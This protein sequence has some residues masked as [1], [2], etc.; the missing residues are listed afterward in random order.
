[1]SLTTGQMHILTLVFEDASVFFPNRVM[2]LR[3]VYGYIPGRL[4]SVLLPLSAGGGRHRVARV[5][6]S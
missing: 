2:N 3:K 6:A 5:R 1:M 4:N